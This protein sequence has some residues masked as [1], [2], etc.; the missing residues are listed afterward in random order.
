MARTS[1]R[2]PKAAPPA[3][4]PEVTDADVKAAQAAAKEAMDLIGELEER[5]INGDDT[6]TPD[7]IAAQESLGRFA[8]LR[9]AA[10]LRKAAGAKEAARLRD[11]QILHDEMTAYAGQD[12]QRLADLYQAIYDAREEFRSIM[13]ER[14]DTVLSWHQR[15]QALDISQEDGRPTPK[16]NDGLIS[17]GRGTFAVK[18]DITVF[19]HED[20]DNYLG[21]HEKAIPFDADAVQA[22]IARLRQIDTPDQRTV[23]EYIY[24]GPNG[25]LLERDRPFTDEEVARTGVRRI[26]AAEAWP[27]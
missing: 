7:E 11:C 3:T 8:R 15:A 17:L 13:E 27:E 9:A 4:I 18:T 20:I 19:G 25:A 26:T 6:V 16:A 21:T 23:P 12:G 2:E 5:V 24:R 1:Q 10:T 22:K 14:N